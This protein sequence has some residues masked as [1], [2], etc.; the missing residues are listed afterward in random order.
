CLDARTT[1]L[2]SVKELHAIFNAVKKLVPLDRLYVN[3]NAGL[4]FL[5]HPQALAKVKRLVQAVRTYT[6]GK[7]R[8]R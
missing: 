4:E 3:P 8:S 1:T 2:E 5:P 6:H 7:A